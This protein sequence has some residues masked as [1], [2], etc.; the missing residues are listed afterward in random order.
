MTGVVVSVDRMERGKGE[1]SALEEVRDLYGIET[2]AIVT[3]REIIEALH[4]KPV[5]GKI[6]IDDAVKEK[7]E[8]YLAAYGAK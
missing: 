2:Y 3:V 5:D 6:Y 4:N 1:R 8:A 7:M